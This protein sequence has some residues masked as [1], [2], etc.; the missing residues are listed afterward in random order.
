MTLGLKTTLKQILLGTVAASALIAAP[1]L[2]LSPGAAI[3]GA[4]G[5]TV[6]WGFT[7]TNDL[8]WIEVVQAQFC[9][10][11][12]VNNPCFL[13]STQFVDIISN[14]PNDVIV[15]PSGSVSQIY[16]PSSNLGLGS[17]IISP[18]AA[19]GSSVVGNILLT[20]NTFDADPNAGGNQIGFNDAISARASVTTITES[21]LPEP[22]TW[23]LAGIGLAG[24]VARRLRRR[25]RHA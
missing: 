18:G 22:T 10:D 24:L 8:N 7:L 5:S 11:S 9:L 23:G 13:A 3:S 25:G 19:I 6:G 2:N 16:A 15:G 21:T 1:I 12:P 17:F 20:Y 4:P 14:P